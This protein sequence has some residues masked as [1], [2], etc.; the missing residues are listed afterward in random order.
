MADMKMSAMFLF[1][2]KAVAHTYEVSFNFGEADMIS[3]RE[4]LN[5]TGKIFIICMFFSFILYLL[6]SLL[7]YAVPEL[8][9]MLDVSG[10]TSERTAI[11]LDAGHGGRDGGAVGQN[12]ILEKDLNLAVTDVLCDILVL[13]GEETIMTN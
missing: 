12:G 11:V 13:C 10:A 5:Y 2:R 1:F 8:G 7:C 3:K 9:A 4:S 6:Y